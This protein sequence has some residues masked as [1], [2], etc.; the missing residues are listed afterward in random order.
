MHYIIVESWDSGNKHQY[1]CT[2]PIWVSYPFW[3]Q[4]T[5]STVENRQRYVRLQCDVIPSLRC[6]HGAAP[7]GPLWRKCVFLSL[8]ALVVVSSVLRHMEIWWCLVRE[9][10]RMDNVVFLSLDLPSGLIC[11]RLCVH[12]RLNWD[13]SRINWR[14]YYFMRPVRMAAKL[15]SRIVSTYDNH[16]VSRSRDC[17]GCKSSTLQMFW[18]TLH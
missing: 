8:P 6:V 18:L 10:Q 4:R 2:Q 16:D 13:S 15:P 11:Y 1:C 3:G 9:R 12:R 17:L 5:Y 14:Q 7:P